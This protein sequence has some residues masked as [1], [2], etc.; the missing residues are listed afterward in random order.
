MKKSMS[1]QDS[2]ISWS[3]IKSNRNMKQSIDE[4]NNWCGDLN[5]VKY[6][7]LMVYNI[8]IYHLKT[9]CKMLPIVL[10]G[11]EDSGVLIWT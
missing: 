5:T 8:M 1:Y 2:R 7:V 11:V 10:L 9:Q 3:C 6:F 4:H